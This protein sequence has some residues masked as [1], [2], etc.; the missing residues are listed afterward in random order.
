MNFLD[1][2]AIIVDNYRYWLRRPTTHKVGTRWLY[3]MLNPSTADASA[4]DPTIRRCFGF[5]NDGG[6]YA[7]GV[8]NLFAHRATQPKDLWAEAT[9][10][11]E[12]PLNDEF[13]RRAAQWADKI[14]LAWGAPPSACPPWFKT[15]WTD[16][17]AAVT[18]IL[19]TQKPARQIMS[20][21]LT[22][23][24]WPR[25][26]LYLSRESKLQQWKHPGDPILI[27]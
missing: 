21:A 10:D 16:R 25:H 17:V 13:T 15:L 8:I 3:V 18:Q 1:D 4:D 2:Q 19:E 27:Q 23:E 24:G 14:V 20:L 12:G 26:P 5:A 22:K 9:K 11:P 6:A 7:F